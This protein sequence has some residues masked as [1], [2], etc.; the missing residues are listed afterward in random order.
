MP[1]LKPVI[2][3]RFDRSKITLGEFIPGLD[4]KMRY[5]KPLRKRIYGH[6]VEAIRSEA[7]K[8]TLYYCMEDDDIWQQTLGFKPEVRGGIPAMLDKSAMEHCDLG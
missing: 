3:R 6:I 1:D 8:M 5:F 4:G 2:N 7:P